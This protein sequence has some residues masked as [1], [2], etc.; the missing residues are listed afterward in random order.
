MS[1]SDALALKLRELR[2]AYRSRLSASVARVEAIWAGLRTG[3]WQPDQATTMHRLVHDLA[4]SGTTF[5]LHEVS[6]CARR[7]EQLLAPTRELQRQPGSDEFAQIDIELRH[8]RRLTDELAGGEL[9]PLGMTFPLG[10]TTQQRT[11]QLIY[12]VDNDEIQAHDLAFQLECFGYQVVLFDTL[13]DLP[14]ADAEPQPAAVVLDLGSAELPVAETRII[15]DL[16]DRR[17]DPLPLM[18]ISQR[19]DLPA[20]LE[21]VR[22]GGQAYFHKPVDVNQLIDTLDRFTAL[23]QHEPFRVLIIDDS[24][25]LAS[26]FAAILGSAG[27]LTEIVTDPLHVLEPLIE[28]R[29]DLILM[30]VYMPGC[31][32][33]E[34][35]AV[36]RQENQFVGVPIVFVSGETDRDAQLAAM[37]RGGDDF[38]TKPITP[39][40][41][42]S[43]VISRAQRARAMR[44]Q[45]VRDG[46]T[47]LLNHTASETQL[48]IE[49][50]R[51]QRN[52]TPLTVALIDIDHFKQ[53]N[54]TYGHPAGDRVLKTLSRLLQQRLRRSDIIGRYGGEEFMVVLPDTSATNAV[55]LFDTIR[56]NFGMIRYTSGERTWNVT[57]S[58]GVAAMTPSMTATELTGAADAAL[59]TAKRGGRNRVVCYELY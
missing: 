43:A 18:F 42:L 33:Q 48:V 44:A 56:T 55:A 38:L 11:Q 7:V 6:A 21:A 45:M 23:Q 27:M 5:G 47:G 41:L 59:Y 53:V 46:L 37:N 25:T 35:A 34:L 58:C 3:S 32:G 9:P 12:L 28:F 2:E 16:Q 8:L 36:I 30:D 29:P 22:A 24:P 31:T 50:A 10:T 26:Y 19:N 57:F 51:A 4:G 17:D 39:Q 40:H 20:R 49:I 1:G 13:A 52:N 14:A 54:D 15:A